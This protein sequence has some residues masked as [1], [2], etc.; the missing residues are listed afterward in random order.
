MTE[1]L[2]PFLL[3]ILGLGFLASPRT[4][5]PTSGVLGVL[6]VI[7]F[8]FVLY[9]G[10][11]NSTILGIRYLVAELLLVPVTWR[12]SSYLIA[13]SGLG[14]VG[15]LRPPEA[16]EVDLSLERPDLDRLVGHHGRALTTPPSLGDGRVQEEEGSTAPPRM[17]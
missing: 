6:A 17:D 13:G 16:H 11:T 7:C 4:C 5:C 10:F 1:L 9:L 8:S 15:Y 12:V 3:L 2:L 14:R